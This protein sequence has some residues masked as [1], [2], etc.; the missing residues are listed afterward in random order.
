[1]MH[2]LVLDL[3][4]KVFINPSRNTIFHLYSYILNTQL[5]YS[6]IQNTQT[7]FNLYN[8]SP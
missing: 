8:P 6:F 7:T 2:M 4:I 1:M 5:C 3:L